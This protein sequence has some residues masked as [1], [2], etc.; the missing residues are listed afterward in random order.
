MTSSDMSTILAV[1]PTTV[2]K[3]TVFFCRW[4]GWEVTVLV[5]FRG[6]HK[7]MTPNPII[8]ITFSIILYPGIMFGAK[9][10]FIT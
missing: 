6:C 4:R 3:F 2:L 9:S 1:W 7:C 10:Q 8:I 5:I